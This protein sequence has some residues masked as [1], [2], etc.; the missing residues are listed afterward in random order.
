MD[1]ITGLR[2]GFSIPDAW[3]NVNTIFLSII[4]EAIPFI[5]IGVFVSSLIQIFVSEEALQRFI[6]KNPWIALVPA[7]LLAAFFPSIIKPLVAHG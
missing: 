6:P 2:A 4:F 1:L 3:L 5:L 7:T